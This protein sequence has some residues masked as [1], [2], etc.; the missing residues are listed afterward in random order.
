MV[1]IL[2]FSKLFKDR[3]QNC[4]VISNHAAKVESKYAVFLR[5]QKKFWKKWFFSWI[6]A[7]KST[8]AFDELTEILDE[9]I[10]RHHDDFHQI[11][12]VFANMFWRFWE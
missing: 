6:S 8:V 9:M 4:H 7:I 12:K 1:Y 2:Y 3:F 11:N 5:S 10:L